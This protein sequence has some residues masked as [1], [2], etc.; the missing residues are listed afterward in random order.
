M[1]FSSISE[2][3]VRRKSGGN[4]LDPSDSCIPYHKTFEAFETFD[5][6]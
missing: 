2:L 6:F 5:A 4:A 1:L 3:N